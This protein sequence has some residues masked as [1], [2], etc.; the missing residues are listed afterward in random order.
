MAQPLILG[1][2]PCYQ[3]PNLRWQTQRYGPSKV[4]PAREH[5]NWRNSLPF[6]TNFGPHY[7]QIMMYPLGIAPDTRETYIS[8]ACRPQ[9][10]SDYVPMAYSLQSQDVSAAAPDFEWRHKQSLFSR[11]T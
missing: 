1:S 8:P 2:L 11:K 10:P 9:L 3:A 5:F 7:P 6:D 4:L